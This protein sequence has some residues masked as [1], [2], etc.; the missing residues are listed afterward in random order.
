VYGENTGSGYAG[1]FVGDGY[2]SGNV[3][4]GTTIPGVKLDVDGQIRA[5]NGYGDYISLGGDDAGGDL[6]VTIYAPASRNGI[7]FWNAQL[8]TP[9]NI[10]AATV[11]ASTLHLTSDLRLKKNIMPIDGALDKV[12]SLRGVTFE[13]RREES[14]SKGFDEGKKM[15]LIAQEVEGVLPEVVSRNVQNGNKSV[16]YANLVAVL[17]EA[18]K[19]LRVQN[20]RLQS[21]I[22][23]LE[24]Q[25]S[26]PQG[27]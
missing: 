23:V 10:G 1:Y 25:G 22:E 8:A 13:W 14:F 6:E 26:S 2:F 18:V 11:S 4:I 21:R 12:A 5:R 17:I 19:E 27:R 16:E 24:G 9:A 7:T 20:Q 15:G 3:G